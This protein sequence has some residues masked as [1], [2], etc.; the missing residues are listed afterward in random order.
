MQNKTSHTWVLIEDRFN[1]YKPGL[2]ISYFDERVP[3]YINGGIYFTNLENIHKYYY[4][5]TTMWVVN[6]PA[7][8]YDFIM[9]NN[10]SEI[11]PEWKANKVIL[12]EKYSLLDHPTYEKFNIKFHSSYVSQ[13]ASNPDNLAYLQ[14]FHDRGY[15]NKEHISACVIRSGDFDM[16]T[17]IVENNYI[18]QIPSKTADFHRIE[19]KNWVRQ[20]YPPWDRNDCSSAAAK[21]NLNLLKLLC[22]LG[23]RMD[24][25]VCTYAAKNGHIEI[26]QWARDRGCKW[27]HNA[28][29]CAIENGQLEVLKW[30]KKNNFSALSTCSIAAA[31]GRFEVLKWALNNGYKWDANTCASAASRGHLEILKWAREN[32][33]EWDEFTCSCAAMGGHVEILKWAINNGCPFDKRELSKFQNSNNI[34]LGNYIKSVI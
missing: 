18:W 1:N 15:D 30:L 24:K 26:L 17:W 21:G 10:S 22:W 32:G 31:A 33:C 5:G 19:F 12:K 8:D 20:N 6:F 3:F 27:N 23:C 34:E 4:L 11:S 25:N 28:W 16:L 2:N 29:K 7:H 13:M 14:Q 9:V